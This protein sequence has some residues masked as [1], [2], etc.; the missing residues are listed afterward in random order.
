MIYCHD[1]DLDDLLLDSVEDEL[2]NA[3]L[4]RA[5]VKIYHRPF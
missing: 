4:T 3:A 1:E 2:A 5:T